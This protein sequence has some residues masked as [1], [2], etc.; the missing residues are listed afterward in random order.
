LVLSPEDF[1]WTFPSDF[2]MTNFTYLTPGCAGSIYVEQYPFIYD[3]S[4]PGVLPSTLTDNSDVEID[5]LPLK[6]LEKTQINKDLMSQT[7][8]PPPP[9]KP[10]LYVEANGGLSQSLITPSDQ[11]SY[12]F[13]VGVGTQLQRGK[14][15]FTL[16]VNGILSNHNDI[17]LNRQAKVYGFG[18]TVTNYTINY[19]QIYSLEAVLSV[20]YTM[21]NHT[22]SIGCRPSFIVGSKVGYN[23]L[24][25]YDNEERTLVYGYMDGLSRLGIKPMIG[26]A[27]NVTPGFVVGLN[28]SAQVMNSVNEDYIDGVNNT[29]PIDGQI[30]LRKTISFK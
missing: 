24:D 5:R 4:L 22:V 8:P 27:F 9:A 10:T 2:D 17:V 30:F 20:G 15:Q 7:F 14:F 26:Y 16:G 21:G 11:L 18:S 3:G 1:E 23:A 28:L 25:N 13:G 29:L 19:Q 6:E 12:S